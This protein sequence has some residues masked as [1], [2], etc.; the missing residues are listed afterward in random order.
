MIVNEH[1][2][3]DRATKS[4]LA[5]TIQFVESKNVKIRSKLE[6]VSS[7]LDALRRFHFQVLQDLPLVV[8]SVSVDNRIVSWNNVMVRLTGIEQNTTIGQSVDNIQQLWGGVFF[9]SNTLKSVT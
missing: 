8:V 6:G 7:E 3:I 9:P 4:A 2:P 5:D 1:L